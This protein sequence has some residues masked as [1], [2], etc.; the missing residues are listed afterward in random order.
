M[1]SFDLMIEKYSK[2]LIEAGKKS[3]ASVIEEKEIGNFDME[4]VAVMNETA[5]EISENTQAA[6]LV[7]D[8]DSDTFRKDGQEKDGSGRLKIQAFAAD[9][10]YP[11]VAANVRVYKKGSSTPYFE[12]YTDS[13][14]IIDEIVLPA[15]SGV[16][17]DVPPET[18][19]FFKYD[20]VIT[21]PKFIT[22]RYIDVPIFDNINSIQTVQL[23]PIEY[24][25]D[26]NSDIYENENSELMKREVRNNA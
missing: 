7:L 3:M 10:V 20:I 18:E 15:P 9:G 14:G 22:K 23:V 6:A 5:E 26:E 12:G 25:K 21:H 19:P 2:E 16:N 1:N 17:T 11:V 4:E 8:N 13:S 24:G